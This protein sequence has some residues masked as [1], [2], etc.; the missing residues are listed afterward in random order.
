[1]ESGKNTPGWRVILLLLVFFVLLVLWVVLT[2]PYLVHR[3]S[4]KAFTGYEL[5]LLKY[6]NSDLVEAEIIPTSKV[7]M[8]TD[9]TYH[10]SDDI[11]TVLEFMEQERP[12]FVQLIGSR[13]INEP[14]YANK[15]CAGETA[16][17][18]IFQ[19]LDLGTPCIKIYIYPSTSGGTSIKISENWSSMGFPVW[20]TRF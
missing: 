19:S 13:V 15:S 8:A 2:Q 12:G 7:T 11:A 14:T 9:Y 5:Y 3:L 20:L 17:R 10:T 6:P 16:F 1:M 18:K 4:T